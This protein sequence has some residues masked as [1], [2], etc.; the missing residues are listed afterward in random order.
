MTLDQLNNL[1]QSLGW[2]LLEQGRQFRGRYFP[3][4]RLHGRCL[5]L[6]ARFA[7]VV[8]HLELGPEPGDDWGGA[9]RPIRDGTGWSNHASY[10]AIDLNATEHP[11]HER[12]TFTAKQYAAMRR[13]GQELA[14]AVGRPV[15]R[16]GIDWERGLRRSRRAD[17]TFRRAGAEQD[18]R[19]TLEPQLTFR[20]S[21][22]GYSHPTWG[23]GRWHDELVVA[24]EA[25]RTDAI[26]DTELHHLHVQ[27]VMRATWGDR[28]GLG[29]L[30]QIVIG[31]HHARGLTGLNDGFA[32]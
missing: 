15:L 9:P 23:H 17:L 7:R 31:P 26:D 27:Q 5:V 8:A 10:T 18:E 4:S 6:A 28:V 20:M 21:G 12:G 1:Q 3:E 11:Q 16:L 24:G 19:I 2:R 13:I 30:E 22:V 29:V 14:A 32:G 25:V